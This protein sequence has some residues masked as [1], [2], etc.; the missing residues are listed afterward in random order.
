MVS[1]QL[2]LLSKHSTTST[3]NTVATL[4][5]LLAI[6]VAA[7]VVRFGGLHLVGVGGNDTILYY[8]L[9][10]HW[11]GGEFAFRIGD[12]I[13]VFRPVLLGFNALA[14][15]LLGHTDTA[16][17]FAN[18]GLDLINVL[19]V[20]YLGWLISAKR[21]VALCSAA[22]YAALPMA[23]WASRI[24]LAHTLSTTLAL[25]SFILT[26]LALRSQ[27]PRLRLYL[28]AGSGLMIGA[29]ALTHE[30]L[31]FLAV[32]AALLVA[33]ASRYSR[34]EPLATTCVSIAALA[35]L[36]VASVLAMLVHEGD[37]ISQTVDGALG[38]VAQADRFYPETF[39]HF[40]WNGTMGGSSSLF[41]LIVAIVG[42]YGLVSM[43]WQRARGGMV[44]PERVWQF[45][46]C[47]LPPLTFIAL[48]ALFFGAM[49][50]RNFQPLLPFLIIGTLSGLAY[51][52]GRG[53]LTR[54]GLLVTATAIVIVA[55]GAG[56]SNFN[57]ANRRFSETW[58]EPTW[59]SEKTWNSSRRSLQV[60]ANYVPSY[61]THW[62]MV[63]RALEGVIDADH[64]LLISP[65]T[66]MY[67]AGRRPLQTKVYFG[68]NAVYRV[69]HANV[70]LV[71]LAKDNNIRYVIWTRGQLRRP[72]TQ[73]APY[74]YNNQWGPSQ[75][76]DLAEAYGMETYTEQN[77]GRQI[78]NFMHAW[79]A[80]EIFPFPEGS[81]E[82][83]FARVWELNKPDD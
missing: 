19:L 66:A 45:A 34:G 48:S 37:A 82:Q 46:F 35:V 32:P 40:L 17:K 54:A 30:D 16:I 15:N 22:V 27:R 59:P 64:R 51:L 57:V 10:E 49:F 24:E 12:S 39:F 77:E 23:I 56:Y 60:S 75:A 31:I 21:L 25:A 65:S 3:T 52:G 55:N 78:S 67:A 70:P 76:L 18:A 50:P 74:R 43:L 1:A 9:A 42:L 47:F 41:V 6:V 38:G 69:D 83:R 26:A 28:T 72:P 73:L 11:L 62:A 81:F 14:L 13:T 79:G 44:P 58:A 36:P 5:I 20:A 61:Y 63:H 4:A 80:K 8:T 68:D 53:K 7:G 71:Q 2:P 33:G 29:A